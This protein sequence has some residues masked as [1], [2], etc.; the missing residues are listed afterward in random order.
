MILLYNTVI[1]SYQW[2]LWFHSMISITHSYCGLN[3]FK[4]KTPK[5][6]NSWV[7]NCALLWIV[8]QILCHST[9]SQLGH[10]SS[11]CPAY[12]YCTCYLSDNQV[13][14][15]VITLTAA[16]LWC[17][18]LSDTHFTLM[19]PK[20]K[21]SDADHLDMSK[22]SHKVAS[23]KAKGECFH[24]RRKD[25]NYMLGLLR[26]RLRI[27]LLW[28]YKKKKETCASFAIVSQI[29]KDTATICTCLVKTGKALNVSGRY[30]Q[31]C[32]LT[33]GK[34]LQQKALSLTSSHHA[35][36]VF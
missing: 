30:E 1:R 5:V 19:P 26:S 10:E 36:S 6:N 31:K 17:L 18:Y 35:G 27:N 25:K 4:W 23:F 21:S 16:V 7:L 34:V 8:I 14:V 29:A 12:P 20:C 3:I 9:P 22:R 13:A 28:C 2:F 24:L 32:V 33:D 11:F 15:S